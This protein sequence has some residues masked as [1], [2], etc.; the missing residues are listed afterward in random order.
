MT[1]IRNAQDEAWAN[2][3]ARGFNQ[4]DVSLEFNLLHGEVSEAFTAW[5][6]GSPDLGAELADVFIYTAGLAEMSPRNNRSTSPALTS[7]CRTG[8][9][10]SSPNRKAN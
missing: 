2:K 10:S 5:R 3:V 9:P 4:S 7:G 6:E 1:D 8:H